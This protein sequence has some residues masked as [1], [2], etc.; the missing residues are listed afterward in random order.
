M[1]YYAI[2]RKIFKEIKL[3][4]FYGFMQPTTEVFVKNSKILNSIVFY[5]L[6]YVF[7]LKAPFIRR[8]LWLVGAVFLNCVIQGALYHQ[9]RKF[10]TKP[11]RCLTVSFPTHHFQ[12]LKQVVISWLFTEVDVATEIL[13]NPSYER[14]SSDIYILP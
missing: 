4:Q 12:Q 1:Q 14:N 11:A 5:Y 2:S 6:L 8:H 10:F 3:L 9:T 7:Y 13:Q